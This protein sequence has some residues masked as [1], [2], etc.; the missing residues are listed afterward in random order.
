[1]LMLLANNVLHLAS[2]VTLGYYCELVG[3][4]ARKKM[5]LNIK[6]YFTMNIGLVLHLSS[7]TSCAP[8]LRSVEKKHLQI[9]SSET[10]W[11]F[12]KNSSS[13]GF[14]NKK[15]NCCLQERSLPED[16]TLVNFKKTQGNKRGT[17]TLYSHFKPFYAN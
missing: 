9:L 17:K 16:I 10:S 7:A 2:E 5:V 11:I 15:Q 14:P 4:K 6:P 3:Q 1:M 13:S 12:L 8:F